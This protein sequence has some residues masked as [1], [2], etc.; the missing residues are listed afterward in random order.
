MS[1]VVSREEQIRQG[2]IRPPNNYLPAR[3]IGNFEFH[4]NERGILKGAVDAAGEMMTK[5]KWGDLINVIKGLRA[6]AAT[7][8]ASR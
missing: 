1:N 8:N 5:E 7:P 6:E 4:D 3:P 2:L